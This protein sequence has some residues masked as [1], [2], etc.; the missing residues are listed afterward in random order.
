MFSFFIVSIISNNHC[1]YNPSN[2]KTDHSMDCEIKCIGKDKLQSTITRNGPGYTFLLCKGEPACNSAHLI[3]SDV[4]KC[5]ISCRND[6]KSSDNACNSMDQS[7]SGIDTCCRN[8][9]ACNSMG[10]L[11]TFVNGNNCPETLND[12]FLL[13][14]P[15]P[16]PSPS[17]PPS[18][19]P[20]P[21]PSPSPSPPPSR[22]PSPPPSRSPSPPP[23]TS[24]SPPPSTSPSP[25]PVS[26]PPS[27][28]ISVP[29][30]QELKTDTKCALDNT[31]FFRLVTYDLNWCIVKCKE[32][33]CTHMSVGYNLPDNSNICMGCG[34]VEHDEGHIGFTFYKMNLDN[35][36][37]PPPAA[38][39]P[40]QCL[41]QVST[42]TKC[43]L[44]RTRLFKLKTDNMA[45]CYD[46]CKDTG[47]THM[48]IGSWN[49]IPM[50]MGCA[51][52]QDVQ[53]S[54]SFV[55]HKVNIDYCEITP[56]PPP[57]AY[58]CDDMFITVMQDY[59]CGTPTPMDRYYRQLNVPTIDA[60]RQLCLGHPEDCNFYSYASTG[61]YAGYCMGC[62]HPDQKVYEK[63]FMFLPVSECD[64]TPF[65]PDGI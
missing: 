61:Q 37:A 45:D 59:K 4:S 62:T 22:S 6:G 33:E 58:V 43:A 2:C 29:C 21:P 26:P 55:L 15:P 12:A 23:S 20:S 48:S 50:C 10:N 8:D 30:I 57:P 3:C 5:Y 31:R 53:T 56:P 19:S 42:Y 40:P 44:D 13:H 60:C 17:P 32:T 49:N 16:S 65:E 14:S 47:C 34:N 38:P 27:S 46:K 1:S 41:E 9:N 52:D 36:H 7:S 28:P 24:P 39:P 35:C 11:N 63:D 51:N 18:P 25:P 54:G 64:G